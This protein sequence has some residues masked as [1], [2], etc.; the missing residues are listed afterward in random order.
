MRLAALAFLSFCISESR[1]CSAVKITTRATVAQNSTFEKLAFIRPFSCEPVTNISG[2]VLDTFGR[3]LNLFT[4]V[5]P[6]YL[7]YCDTLQI[8]VKAKGM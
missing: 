3:D 6:V 8:E 4:T 7:A 1:V 5:G 2:C